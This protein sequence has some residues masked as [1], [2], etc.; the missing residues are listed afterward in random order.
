LVA[1]R[2]DEGYDG[3]DAGTEDAQYPSDIDEQNE[4]HAK[5]SGI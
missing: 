5:T 3:K 4:R 1:S 2:E